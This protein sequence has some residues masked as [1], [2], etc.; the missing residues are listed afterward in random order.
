MLVPK[1]LGI[2]FSGPNRNCVN[3]VNVKKV[4]HFLVAHSKVLTVHD[5][6]AGFFLRDLMRFIRFKYI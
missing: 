2:P 1:P 3:F 4:L 5:V 6:K